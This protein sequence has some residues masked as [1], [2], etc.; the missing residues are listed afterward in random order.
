MPPETDGC[1]A[2]LSTRRNTSTATWTTRNSARR[3]WQ[4]DDG[5]MTRHDHSDR[6]AL[7]TTAPES[8]SEELGRRKRRYAIMAAIFIASFST[9]ALLHRDTAAALLLCGVAMTTLV[10]AVIGANVR[11]PRRRTA[12]PVHVIDNHNQLLSA[13]VRRTPGQ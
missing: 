9:A 5:P 13:P 3:E 10:L 7:I 2:N 11:S 6:P 8:L 1:G 4:V 12:S